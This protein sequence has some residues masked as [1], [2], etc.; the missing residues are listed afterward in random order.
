MNRGSSVSK[1]PSFTISFSKPTNSK[2]KKE[3]SAIDEIDKLETKEEKR[4][5]LP[6]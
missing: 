3:D 5:D 1:V 2:T 4:E 6:F